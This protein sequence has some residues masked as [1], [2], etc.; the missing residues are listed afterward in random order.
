MAADGAAGTQIQESA[1][2]GLSHRQAK[3]QM[4]NGYLLHPHQAGRAVPVHNP[5]PLR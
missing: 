2:Q 3:Q 5:G 4:G 1:E